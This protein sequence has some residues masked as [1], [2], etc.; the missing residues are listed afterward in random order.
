MNL[1]NKNDMAFERNSFSKLTKV[2]QKN[3][4]KNNEFFREIHKSHMSQE[5]IGSH[6]N[7]LLYFLTKK[8]HTIINQTFK[9]VVF[10]I[11]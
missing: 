7:S 5:F 4:N 2:K 1:K 3:I 6:L 9:P 11:L 10:I 8:T